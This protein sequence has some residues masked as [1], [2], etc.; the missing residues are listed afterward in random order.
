MDQ[1]A[2]ELGLL[3]KP[4]PDLVVGGGAHLDRH[5]SLDEGV[6]TLENDTESADGNLCDHLVF[7]DRLRGVH[8][9][10]LACTG[11]R[12]QPHR[13]LIGLSRILI[14]EEE[15]QLLEVDLEIDCLGEHS[16]G[17]FDPDRGKIENAAESRAAMRSQIPW[18]AL[19]GVVMTP[20]STFR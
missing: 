20:I 10:T 16:F 7:A 6:P 11:S 17:R 14:G 18:A 15:T 3:L 5:G 12:V 4:L 2:D 9:L 1:V 19:A 8:P 13:S